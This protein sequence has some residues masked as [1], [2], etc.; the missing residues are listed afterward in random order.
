MSLYL[1]LSCFQGQE[2]I[3]AY[4]KLLKLKPDGIQLTPGNKV[5]ANFKEHQTIPYRLH[6]AFSW[7]KVKDPI[8]DNTGKICRKVLSNQSIHPPVIKDYKNTF[9]FWLNQLTDEIVELMF[10]TYY[11]GN[12][13]EINDIL[14]NKQKIAVDISHLYICQKKST[15]TEATLRRIFN[16]SNISEI[17]VSQN[18]GTRDSHSPITKD[19]PFIS[20]AKEKAQ[21][22]PIVFESYF[23]KIS[24]KEQLQQVNLVRQL[25]DLREDS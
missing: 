13:E 6:H 19:C 21:D 17:H 10:P 1:A 14:D 4:N 2:Q 22:T 20:W 11:G 9:K 16:Y 23:L 24:E 12:E 7:T 18:D 3:E 15:I 25:L 8:Y 5:S